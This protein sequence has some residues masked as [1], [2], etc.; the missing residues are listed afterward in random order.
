MRLMRKLAAFFCAAAL[1]CGAADDL[2]DNF[3]HMKGIAQREAARGDKGAQA[4]LE[5]IAGTSSDPKRLQEGAGW[6][7]A[8]AQAGMP[9]AQ[10]QLA[11]MLQVQA[12]KQPE[13]AEENYRKAAEL[14]RKAADQNYAQA[15]V[16]LATL[17]AKGQGV[18]QDNAKAMEWGHKAARGGDVAAMGWLGAKYLE[19]KIVK[20]DVGVG[21][22]WLEKAANQGNALSQMILATAY[23]GTPDVPANPQKAK[24]WRERLATKN[25][26][27]YEGDLL[28][29]A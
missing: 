18:P 21:L 8:K 23:L 14:F 9:E 5:T 7:L 20:K 15:Q 22:I 29:V 12:A 16:E 26:V 1:A 28:A 11:V 13:R 10:T 24:Y 4:Y 6:L 2:P 25:V 17:Y 19:G 3:V 27:E